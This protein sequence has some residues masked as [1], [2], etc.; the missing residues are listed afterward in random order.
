[1]H[2]KFINMFLSFNYLLKQ[3]KRESLPNLLLKQKSNAITSQVVLAVLLVTLILR[4]VVI[5][6]VMMLVNFV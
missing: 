6:F 5:I 4:Q 3:V 2:F 1:M